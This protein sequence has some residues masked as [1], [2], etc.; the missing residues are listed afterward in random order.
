MVVEFTATV[1]EALNEL[2]N[3]E[4]K[5]PLVL[6]LLV[7]VKLVKS[8]VVALSKVVKKLVEDALV[9]VALTAMVLEAFRFVT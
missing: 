1:F 7:V 2:A 8:A 6:V 3:K 5:N 9:V 4:V